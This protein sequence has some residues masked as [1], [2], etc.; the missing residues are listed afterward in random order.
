MKTT[1]PT[2]GSVPAQE[3]GVAETGDEAPAEPARV[4]EYGKIAP[5]FAGVE[6]PAPRP[7]GPPGEDQGSRMARAHYDGM[8][9]DEA[10]EVW[11][12]ESLCAGC[13]HSQ[14]CK[15]VTGATDALVVVSRCVAYLPAPR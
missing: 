1:T 15:F 4:P 3:I 10:T 13:L 11:K 9:A 12:R 5:G 7:M 14:V 2:P 8:E 6:E